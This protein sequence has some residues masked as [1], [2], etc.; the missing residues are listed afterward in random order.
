MWVP[1]SGDWLWFKLLRQP[2]NLHLHPVSLLPCPGSH[3]RRSVRHRD[4][5]VELRVYPLRTADRISALRGW[6]WS[7]SARVYSWDPRNA[8]RPP[9][10][11]RQT[12]AALCQLSGLSA[13]LPGRLRPGRVHSADGGTVTEGKVPWAPRNQRSGDWRPEELRGPCLRRL[14]PTL[15]GSG[16]AVADDPRG[17]DATSVAVCPAKQQTT[18]T[19]SAWWYYYYHYY[20]QRAQS[21]TASSDNYYNYYYN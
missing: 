9:A 4:R 8:S 1:C 7:R 13:L 21:S 10:G 15:S 12:H 17:G 3:S 11:L 14:S 2:A 6:G 18:T 16:S 20:A 19:T 5:H